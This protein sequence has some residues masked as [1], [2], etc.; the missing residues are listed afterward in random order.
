MRLID[1]DAFEASVE[2]VW[3]KEEIT[4]EEMSRI[5]EMIKDEPTVEPQIEQNKRELEEARAHIR[6]LQDQMSRDSGMIEGLKYAIRY[7][8]VGGDDL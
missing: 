8:K 4:R 1:A 3:F 7:H 2:K 6:Y 5:L